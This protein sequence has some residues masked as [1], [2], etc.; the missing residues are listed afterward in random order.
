MLCTNSV[1]SLKCQLSLNL[2]LIPRLDFLSLRLGADADC[3]QERGGNLAYTIPFSCLGI[4][5][6]VSDWQVT[7][8]SSYSV[9]TQ[10]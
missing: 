4:R 2:I 9:C 6:R 3:T 5:L 8:I 7:E 10:L 1:C